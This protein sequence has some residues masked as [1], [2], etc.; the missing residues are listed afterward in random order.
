MANLLQ[1]HGDQTPVPDP[2][3]I[4]TFRNRDGKTLGMTFPRP[5]GWWTVLVTT[6]EGKR[7]LNNRG[8]ERAAVN[9]IWEYAERRP[10]ALD[11]AEDPGVDAFFEILHLGP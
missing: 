5:D 6:P 1:E 3:G 8:S 10:M 7:Q 11:P 4:T 2:S 9:A